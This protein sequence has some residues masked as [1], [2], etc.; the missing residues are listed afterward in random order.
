MLFVFEKINCISISSKFLR[1]VGWNSFNTDFFLTFNSNLWPLFTYILCYYCNYESYG[2]Q[3]QEGRH[4]SLSISL[5]PPKSESRGSAFMH[6]DQKRSCYPRVEN[7]VH[8]VH[9]V[10][11]TCTCHA[12]FETNYMPRGS[13]IT[14][15][16]FIAF[17]YSFGCQ[18]PWLQQK[19]QSIEVKVWLNWQM[20]SYYTGLNT[21]NTE[22]TKT[23]C[24]LLK[25][26]SD[27]IVYYCQQNSWKRPKQCF[28]IWLWFC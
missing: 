5:P 23:A 2:R 4:Q 27:L 9:C 16:F 20:L 19:L 10:R 21:K 15:S 26:L 8:T 17:K 11:I 3:G 24:V 1:C 28:S 6:T 14:R 25:D 22:K 13:S 12:G 7:T 18:L